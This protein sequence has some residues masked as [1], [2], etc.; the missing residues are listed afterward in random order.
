MDKIDESIVVI[1]SR[2]Q[3]VRYFSFD[4]REYIFYNVPNL[5]I[6]D[7]AICRFCHAT[8]RSICSGQVTYHYM[9]ESS[10]EI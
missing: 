1:Y 8:G 9:T 4:T 10:N 7:S 5:I 2:L 3:I 6:G